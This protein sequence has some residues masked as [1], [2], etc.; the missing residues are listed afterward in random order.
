MNNFTKNEIKKIVSDLMKEMRDEIP[1]GVS[2]RHIHLSQEDFELLFPGETLEPLKMLKQPGEFAA[3]QT[4]TLIGKKGKQ[5]KVRILGPLR[6][7][8]Q[9]E[10]SKTDARVLGIDAPIRLSG[11]LIDAGMVTL[12]SVNNEVS[13]R[14]AIVAKRHIH[15]NHNDLERFNL[16]ED[17]VLTVK[18]K[19]PER[20]TIYKDV[21]IRLGEKF[22]LEMHIDTDEANAA[23]VT[24]ST[25]ALLMRDEKME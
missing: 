6:K 12:K 2:N 13:L 21:S 11:N 4:L 15:M 24:N 20:E 23:N 5:E 16:K 9:V 3:K 8:T 7:R 18:L 10:I 14:A 25:K 17:D 1:V 22:I 19:T